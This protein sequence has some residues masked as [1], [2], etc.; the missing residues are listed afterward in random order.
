ML[1]SLLPIE[2]GRVVV[3]IHLL[4]RLVNEFLQLLRGM[5]QLVLI[6]LRMQL[7][8]L[9][10]IKDIQSDFKVLLGVLVH[11]DI[12]LIDDLGLSLLGLGVLGFIVFLA[13]IAFRGLPVLVFG[14]LFFGRFF[15]DGSFG[16]AMIHFVLH[17]SD[18]DSFILVILVFDGLELLL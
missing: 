9:T 16:L 10:R 11:V 17:F 1:L 15:L 2:I 12:I 14:V 8:V 7:F 18:G 13:L 5:G 3:V 6:E 4:Y